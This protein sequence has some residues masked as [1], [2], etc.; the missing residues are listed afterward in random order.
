M[1][2]YL[3]ISSDVY[4]LPLY[5]ADTL[6]DALNFAFLLSKRGVETL[7]EVVNI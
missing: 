1:K 5:S 7:I 6:R 2:Q 3:V 4:E